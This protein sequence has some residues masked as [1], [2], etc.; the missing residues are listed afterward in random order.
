MDME[1]NQIILERSVEVQRFTADR[2][3]DRWHECYFF[4]ILIH[5]VESDRLSAYTTRQYPKEQAV[6][7]TSQKGEGRGNGGL[8]L[9]AV[10][11]TDAVGLPVPERYGR[12]VIGLRT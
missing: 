9:P 7:T 11:H 10:H 4:P 12:P 8:A 2:T 1:P 3:F 5:S 6:N